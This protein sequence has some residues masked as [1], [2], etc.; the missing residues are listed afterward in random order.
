M[1]KTV[2]I[3]ALIILAFTGNAQ[4]AVARIKYGQAEE[5]FE[6]NDY[7]LTL[8][9][10]DE[11]QKLLGSTNPKILYLRLMAAKGL[12]ANGRF[13]WDFLTEA[14]KNAAYYIRQY[15]EMQGI[16]E[17]FRQ[18]YEFSETLEA[19]PKTTVTTATAW[20][21]GPQTFDGVKLID[22]LTY[23]RAKN[24]SVMAY[25]LNDYS[26]GIPQEDVLATTVLVAYRHNGQYMSI[27]NKGPL[28]IIY[29]DS[30]GSKDIQSKMIWQLR[31]LEVGPE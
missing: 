29:P 15:S 5:A 14:R 7:A 11:A 3:A 20:N 17:K 23:L 19:L 31:T 28:W 6:K 21:D 26:V 25:A 13:D 12:I 4:N 2:L 10:L 27:A 18:V 1:M 22:L 16:E 8:V 9:R 24:M 30:L